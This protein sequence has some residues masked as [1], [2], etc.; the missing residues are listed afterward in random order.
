MDR[1]LLVLLVAAV[2]TLILALTYI[3]L[4]LFL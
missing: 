2:N 3:I 1:L 4:E